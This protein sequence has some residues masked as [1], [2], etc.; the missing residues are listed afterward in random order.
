M[1]V[2]VK[3]D[4][5]LCAE[6]LLAV[7]VAVRFQREPSAERRNNRDIVERTLLCSSSIRQCA[8]G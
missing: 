5:V 7:T 3:Q 1:G 6:L 4:L 2:Q 8:N